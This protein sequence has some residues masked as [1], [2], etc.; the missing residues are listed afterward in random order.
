[1]VVLLI[2]REVECG[3]VETSVVF[4]LILASVKREKLSVLVLTSNKQVEPEKSKTFGRSAL[5]LALEILTKILSNHIHPIISDA[6]D[7]NQL[8]FVKDRN[9]MDCILVVNESVG[10]Y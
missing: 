7:G 3:M 6:I 4:I 8:A 9:I 1:M 2:P 5:S 10:N